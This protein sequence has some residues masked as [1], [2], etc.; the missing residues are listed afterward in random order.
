MKKASRSR[1]ARARP[2]TRLT[3]KLGDPPIQRD[4]VAV[5]RGRH[6]HHG[7]RP[8]AGSRCFTRLLPDPDRFATMLLSK[9]HRQVGRARLEKVCGVGNLRPGD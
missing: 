2:T 8:R 6:G 3:I 9:P 5:C 1:K 4:G 7:F